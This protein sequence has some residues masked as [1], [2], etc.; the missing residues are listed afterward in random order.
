MCTVEHI[1]RDQRGIRCVSLVK[2]QLLPSFLCLRRVA[3]FLLL[4]VESHIARFHPR[5]FMHVV[6]AD[7]VLVYE[8][9]IPDGVYV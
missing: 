4:S 5:P 1:A 2:R 9:S 6:F 8:S 3:D 7:A